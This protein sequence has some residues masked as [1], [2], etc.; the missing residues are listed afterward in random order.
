MSPASHNVL[1][2][3]SCFG[4]EF[5]WRYALTFFL[6]LLLL[7]RPLLMPESLAVFALA[8]VVAI[9]TRHGIRRLYQSITLH[10]IG[11]T[12]AGLFIIHQYYYL[13][14]PFFQFSWVEQELIRLQ[15]PL[16]WFIHLLLL[17]CLLLFWTG[18]RAM[19]KRAPDYYP[20]CLQFDRGLG[21]LFIMLLVR[22]IVEIKG[23]PRLVDPVT[24]Y[25]LFAYFTFS[26]IAISLSRKQNEVQRTYRPG[27]HGIGVILSATAIII[28]GG[29]ILTALFLPYLA[30]VA[31]T[32]HGVL[33][34]TTEPMGPV[35]VSIIRFL[36]SMGKYRQEMGSKT[37]GGS[38]GERLYPDGEFGLAQVLGLFLLA[39]VGLITLWLCGQLIRFLVRR[40][41]KI[42]R[43]DKPGQSLM[44]LLSRLLSII[45]AVFRPV[46]SGLCSL[47]KPMDS[48]AAIYAGML[49]W[50]HRSGMP[51]KSSETPLEY[52]N[53][54]VYV[55]PQLQTEIG[56][57]VDAFNREFYGKIPLPGKAMNSTR[58]ARRR[59]VNPR[60]WL[61][62]L[63]ALLTET[64]A[65]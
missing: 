19:V 38:I 58:T 35:I 23:G 13:N 6:T 11:Y 49:R 48:A 61:S 62:R 60:H 59:M 3:L 4:M 50:G 64:P 57:I 34:E 39:V 43:R 56:M 9:I 55:F 10:I 28:T 37:S 30:Q 8:Y 29:A 40:L 5:T 44:V 1:L 52:G 45:G 16:Q 63:K 36:L 24:I 26:L 14:T 31:D 53:R 15:Q 41:M 25:L 2:K 32:A 17:A 22:F 18:A 27:Y 46:W 47:V 12:I 51:A 33:K 65:P 7:N 42:E 54:L 20:V 21:A